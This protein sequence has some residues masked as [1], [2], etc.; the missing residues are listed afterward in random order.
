[1]YFVLN[2]YLSK[3]KSHWPLDQ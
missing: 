3:F 1:M 2:I